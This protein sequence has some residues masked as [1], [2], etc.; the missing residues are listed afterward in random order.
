MFLSGLVVYYPAKSYELSDDLESFVHVLVIQLLRY[1][2]HSMTRTPSSLYKHVMH[3]YLSTDGVTGYQTGQP[4]KI[5][6]MQDG[7]VS[8]VL[9]RKKDNS[10]PFLDL[11]T[12][13][14]LLCQRHYQLLDTEKMEDC[15]RFRPFTKVPLKDLYNGREEDSP[16]RNHDAMI[17]AFEVACNSSGWISDKIGD[18]FEGL[19]K[20]RFLSTPQNKRSSSEFE[21]STESRKRRKGPGASSAYTSLHPVPE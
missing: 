21:E 12:S 8:D 16:L 6:H 2:K 11:L 17:A 18:Q 10:P 5:T 7:R 3:K 9:L 20:K 19:F 4:T 14:V 1:H 13:L 15:L